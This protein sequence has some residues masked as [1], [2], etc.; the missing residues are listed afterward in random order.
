MKSYDPLTPPSAE[1]W[2]AL[3]EGDVLELIEAYHRKARIPLPNL[4]AHAALPAV[5]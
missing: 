3:D 5:V 4:K 1:E 2:P